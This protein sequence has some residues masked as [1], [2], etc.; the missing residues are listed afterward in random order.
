[1]KSIK[2][3]IF[4]VL[5]LFSVLLFFALKNI[6][7]YPS[8]FQ[9]SRDS[10]Y[11]NPP[12]AKVRTDQ[13]NI[14]CPL[15]HAKVGER[16]MVE[17]LE[18]FFRSKGKSVKTFDEIE[19]YKKKNFERAGSAINIFIYGH[20]H[21]W[22]NKN[23]INIIYLLFPTTAPLAYKSFDFIAVASSKY[24]A[25]LRKE[26]LNA[27]YVPQFT[28]S[29]R[30]KP[31]PN[32]KLKSKLLFVGNAY[33]NFRLAVKYAVLNHFEIDVYGQGWEEFISKKMIKGEYV[34]NDDLH[35]Y[36]SSA[37]IVLNVHRDD[38]LQNSFISNRTFDVTASGGFLVSDYIPEIEEI[39]G[40]LIPM[41]HN[42]EDY[43]QIVRYYLSHPEERKQKALKAREITLKNF[44]VE[45]IGERFLEEI[46]KIDPF[47]DVSHS[48]FLMNNAF[49]TVPADG[50]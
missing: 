27:A 40:D 19:Y 4:C 35:R 37:D 13:I 12:K 46:D 24:P 14:I 29:S 15:L 26:G 10:Y 33:H 23:G 2:L 9:A 39:Y 48:Q 45:K 36:Y 44:T 1:M 17:D 30:F 25:I 32:E 6:H 34:S 50:N 20:V 21:F 47:K 49:E 31:E 8:Y 22:P 38:M 28:N 11:Q 43:G 5:S 3:V 42:S 18:R 7:Q 41:Y 16:Y